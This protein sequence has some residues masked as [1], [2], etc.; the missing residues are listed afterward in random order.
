LVLENP[1][2][3]AYTLV[4][5][6]MTLPETTT[7]AALADHMGVS[8]RYVRGL[9]RKLGACRIFGHAMRLT[10]DDVQAIMEAVKPCPSR[11]IAVR[12]ALSGS[13]GERLPEID[14]V[15]LLAL[16]TKKPRKELRPRLKTSSGSVVLMEKRRR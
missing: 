5:E 2:L 10:N 15:D 1:Q 8:E 13:I 4:D 14:S 6:P 16:L 11:S 9:A 12:E 7:P 3:E